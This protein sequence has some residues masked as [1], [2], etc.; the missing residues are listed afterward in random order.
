MLQNGPLP[1]LLTVEELGELFESP[2]PR[3][4]MKDLRDGLDALGVYQVKHR[5][6]SISSIQIFKY[7]QEGYVFSF[8]YK[9]Y[10]Q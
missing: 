5:V 4:I 8:S 2:A 7:N 9:V 6:Q 1:K 3:R 10:N